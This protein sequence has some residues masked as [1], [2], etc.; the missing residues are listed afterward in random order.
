M[1]TDTVTVFNKRSDANGGFVYR[2]TVLR[3]VSWCDKSA[4]SV[5]AKGGLIA[6]NCIVVRIPE[7]VNADGKTYADPLAYRCAL[8]ASGL[9][10][11]QKGDVIV[12][13]EA[14]GDNWKPAR[15]KQ[16]YSGYMDVLSINDNRRGLAPHFKVVGE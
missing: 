9:W 15:L 3:G 13:G 10:T 7:D 4:A 6:A 8:D 2:P 1:C 12:K 16:I 11:L 5:D 14:T